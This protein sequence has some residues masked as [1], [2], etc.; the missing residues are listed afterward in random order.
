MKYF[1]VFLLLFF[2][3]S[4]L[5]QG[6][7]NNWF[8]GNNAGI[9]FLENGT[10]VPLAGSAMTT[11]EGCSTLSD[12][13]GN[14][15]F[16]TDG[17][18][19]WDKNHVLMP[20][21]NYAAGTGLN[22]DPSS[23]Q[24][25]IIVPKKGDPNIYY[26]FTVDEPHHQNA[27]SYPD[28][29]TDTYIENGGA[30]GTIP[31]DDDG[32][33]NGFNYSIVDLSV[34]GT[35]GSIGDV[36]TRNVHLVTYD[37]DDSE[38]IKYQCS[39]KITAVKNASA[40]GFWVLTQFVDKF[41]AFEVT[42]TGVN[43]IPIV[44]QIEPLIIT[45]GYRR[46]AIGYLK[47]SPDSQ[48]LAIVHQQNGTVQGQ[49]IGNGSVYLY[50]FDNATGIVSN[51]ILIKDNINPYGIEFSAET[52]KLY[53]TDSSGN[54]SELHQFDLEA[55][56]IPASEI[57]I[58][59]LSGT[60]TA[61]QLGPNA[62]I[63]RST[64]GNTLD[65]INDPDADGLDCNFQANGVTL[66]TSMQARFGLPPFITSLLSA[67]IVATNNCEGEATQF[68]LN[69][70]L[71]FDSVEW[72]FGDGTATSDVVNPTHLY[73][74][75][76]TYNVVVTITKEDDI[77]IVS[78]DIIVHT[79]PIAN[80]A[81]TLTECDPDNNGVTTFNLTDNNND[82]LGAQNPTGYD[83]RY[84]ETQED[85]DANTAAI[86]AASYTN[87]SNPQTL[88][89]RVQNRNNTSCYDTTSFEINVT[90][91]PAFND[92]SYSI[93]D[94]A[95]DGDDTN[96]QAT[97]NLAEVTAA[98]VQDTDNFTTVYYTTQA[99]A[100]AETAP[101]PQSLY[102]TTANEQIIYARVVNN[103]FAEC[104]AI[105]PITL[106]VNP[107]P[108]IINNVA[109]IQCDLGI[110][111]D[112]ITQFN[113]EEANNFFTAGDTN[114]VVTYYVNDANAT[115]DTNNITGAYTNTENPQTITAKITNTVTGCSRV[116]PLI[117][118]VNINTT[119]PIVLDNCDDDGTED[120]LHAFNLSDAGVENDTDVILYYANA[121]DALLEQNPISSEYSNTT[122]YEQSV[123]ARI[124]NNNDC[125]LLQEIQL[126]VYALPDI[127][128]EDEAIVCNNTQDYIL[129]T[130]GVTGNPP[131]FS[132]LWS[133]GATTRSIQVNEA[134]I[135]TVMV[136]NINGCGKLRTITVTPSDVAIIDDI[137]VTDL[138]DNN[139]VTV[140]A[141]P[142]GGVN[143]TYLYSI[144]L[145]NGP[146]VAS[147]FFEDVE[148]GL[149]TVYVYDTNGCG[150][151][152]QDISVLA[153][154]KFFTPNGD[155]VNETWQII[156]ISAEIYAKSRVYILDRYGKFLAGVNPKGLGWD[157]IYNG[158]KLPATDYWYIISL[159]DGRTVKGHFSLVR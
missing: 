138:V 135:Y 18:N 70:N 55:D 97:F 108:S 113:L 141:S 111:P 54:N 30:T 50:D 15:L 110:N 72:D 127:A 58:A 31:N 1:T 88:Y 20:N 29:F 154:P 136:T 69:V 27:D 129:L 62:K 4:S 16:Y 63:Y 131:G 78:K 124:E 79:V 2:S 102:N 35:N 3:F 116:L 94:D 25:G 133:T 87:T 74:N 43:E 156:G 96:G 119:P 109:L 7:A 140:L 83:V 67:N 21:G 115:A 112:G 65:V 134:G 52:K 22:G 100:E 40:T 12:P 39:E 45:N 125:T 144:D 121:T 13:L 147:N 86:N 77:T 91:T 128:I 139:T 84:F 98:L 145:P 56:D 114:L 106:I 92:S 107:L 85:A 64:F 146:F 152:E 23:T 149:H 101:L 59:T 132:Y 32:F 57:I 48:K 104:F 44:T 157:G 95:T 137:I 89:V 53:F 105:E 51:P 34:T 9:E 99:N 103:T 142:T 28:Q 42:S 123:Y 90:N 11:N 122:P 5:A 150:I 117:L 158:R 143:T 81:L 41:Y 148:P 10:V 130:S 73:E 24:S 49:A 118:Q 80:T 8:F 155:G 46:N 93:C 60:S 75:T 61:L 33:N 14:L 6:E 76:G 66:T 37:A 82:I 153:I 159:E 151:V 47:A 68:E 17:R 71:E 19:V 120:G 126:V 26:I 38:Q 36:T